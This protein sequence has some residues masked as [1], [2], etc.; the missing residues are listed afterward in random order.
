MCKMP[1]C[2]IPSLPDGEHYSSFKD[3]GRELVLDTR[4]NGGV[5]LY[6]TKP[7]N[8]CVIN[9]DDNGDELVTVTIGFSAKTAIAVGKELIHRV[10]QHQIRLFESF[11]RK[12]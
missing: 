4:N 6:V 9:K 3:F 1:G 5:S 12:L 10:L 8:G 7:L 2:T 11:S